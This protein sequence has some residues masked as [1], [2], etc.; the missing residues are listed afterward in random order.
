MYKVTLLKSKDIVGISEK[1][2]QYDKELCE[3]TGKSLSGIAAYAVNAKNKSINFKDVLIG[4]V[5]V[6]C[7]SG[8]INGFS[9]TVKC[10]VE[11]VGFNCFVTQNKD[12][13]G[14]EEAYKKKAKVIFIADDDKFIAINT[15]NNKVAENSFNT[16]RGYAA[17][18]DLMSKGLTGKT[19]V[20]IGTGPVGF[21]AVSFMMESG[22]R[23]LVYDILKQKAESLKKSFP[24]VEIITD[25]NRALKDNNLIFDA[26]YAK[27][28]IAKEH[29]DDNTLISA[30]GIPL[31][32]REECFPII[33]DRLI[34]DVLEIGVATM[35]FDSLS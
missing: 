5:P 16:G 29:I 32:L 2:V 22:A 4:I 1:L 25:L 34:H 28:I 6:T 7:G 17:A 33:K 35:L 15:C 27:N 30:P 14:L 19:V 11:T 3:K 9:E 12:V 18:L 13:S 31:G 26:T 24:E 23:I 8:I 20:L 10:I 21:G